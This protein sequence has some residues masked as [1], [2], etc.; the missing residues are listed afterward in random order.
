M[1][2]LR[3]GRA[4]A[5][6]A[7]GARGL[8]QRE[9]TTTLA[10]GSLT[11]PATEHTCYGTHSRRKTP[12]NRVQRPRRVMPS[13]R[14]REGSRAGT[15]RAPSSRAPAVPGGRLGPPVG[16]PSSRTRSP[17]TRSSGTRSS[18]TR[19]PSVPGD[20]GARDQ[21]PGRH[22]ARRARV[23]H[24]YPTLSCAGRISG[25]P[26]TLRGDRDVPAPRGPIPSHQ[27]GRRHRAPFDATRRPVLRVAT[28]PGG[29]SVPALGRRADRGS[30]AEHLPN[31]S[32]AE[33]AVSRGAASSREPPRARTSFLRPR[34]SGRRTGPGPGSRPGI[35]AHD[36]ERAR[37]E[38]TPLRHRQNPPPLV[39][40]S[41]TGRPPTVQNSR[42][43]ND[44]SGNRPVPAPTRPADGATSGE[45]RPVCAA[46]TRSTPVVVDTP[47]PVPPPPTSRPNPVGVS[48]SPDLWAHVNSRADHPPHPD[49]DLSTDRVDL[50]PPASL[51]RPTTARLVRRTP[52]LR[53]PPPRAPKSAAHVD[54]LGGARPA[55]P[56]LPSPHGPD[57]TGDPSLSCRATSP[58][59]SEGEWTFE[60]TGPDEL[61]RGRL[62]ARGRRSAFADASRPGPR[63]ARAGGR[64]VS[65][66]R[67][68]TS[69][70]DRNPRPARP[71]GPSPLP[72]ARRTRGSGGS[73]NRPG[74]R[75][76]GLRHPR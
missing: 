13:E 1:N 10:G 55:P 4:S 5:L 69:R 15:R 3:A 7:S 72:G 52:G 53:R 47:P 62:R 40:M 44:S 16:A 48:L 71:P 25:P 68:P 67:S 31:F 38:R 60:A 63:L 34:S 57:R 66:E 42:P 2:S 51:V 64:G 54:A 35:R 26:A 37:E 8:G 14:E 29:R 74:G 58:A 45:C 30:P 65:C 24:G 23:G 46:P 56:T 76:R 6:D 41:A 9:G 49:R 12:A 11:A 59:A 50:S 75:S 61:R 22:P 27:V 39:A 33:C 70:C 21:A 18:G 19:S 36:L 32:A 43:E 73:R 20:P 17:G 28:P